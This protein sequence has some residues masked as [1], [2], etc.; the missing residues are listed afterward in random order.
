MEEPRMEQENRF[1]SRVRSQ[2]C[3]RAPAPPLT[4]PGASAPGA[5]PCAVTCPSPARLACCALAY[6]AHPLCAHP[7]RSCCALAYSA[8]LLLTHPGHLL[9]AHP[10]SPPACS[11][12]VC[13]LSTYLLCARTSS[14]RAASAIVQELLVTGFERVGQ[15]PQ[16]VCFRRRALSAFHKQPS[17]P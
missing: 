11:P 4:S 13:C 15:H 17:V 9:R 3:Q 12:T 5:A 10:P 8:H 16:T 14:P 2:G 6:S 7:P 1:W